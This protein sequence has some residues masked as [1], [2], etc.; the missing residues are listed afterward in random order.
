MSNCHCHTDIARDGSGQ[1]TRYLTALDPAYAEVDGRSIQD[2][3]I[4]AQKYAAQLRFYDIPG[5]ELKENTPGTKISWVEFFRRDV[6]VLAAAVTTAT[7]DAYRSQYDSL[8]TALDQTPD[9]NGF[10]ALFKP[11]IQIMV[12]L[13]GWY[14][15]AI[16]GNPIQEDLLLSIQ[17][18]LAGQVQKMK[19]YAEGYRIVDV[20]RNITLDFTDIVNDDIW[21]VNDDVDPDNTIFQ[22]DTPEDQI[23]NA[24][25]YID[26][27]FI[28]FYNSLVQL[29]NNGDGYLQFALKAYP[30]HQPHMGLF[31]SF[32]QLFQ[33]VQTQMNDITGRMLD[34]YY[35]DV[36]HLTEKPSVP[37]KA[38][39]IF[40]LAKD[41]KEYSLD[42]G[43]ALSAGK[44]AAGKEQTYI[45]ENPLV[46]NQAKVKELK[47]IFINKTP[48]DG[49]EGAKTIQTIYARPVANSQDGMGAKFIDKYP[50]WPTFGQGPASDQTFTDRICRLLEHPVP[51]TIRTDKASIGFAV[52]SPQL[53]LQGGRRW[54]MVAFDGLAQLMQQASK[55]TDGTAP[56]SI[57]FTGEKE[58][59]Q[60]NIQADLSAVYKQLNATGIFG[61]NTPQTP[62]YSMITVS[63]TAYLLIYL[64]ISA[65]SVIGFDPK[66][67]TGYAFNTSLPVMRIM[68]NPQLGLSA[69]DYRNLQASSFSIQVT[70]G[71]M[72]KSKPTSTGLTSAATVATGPFLD[73]LRT[74]VIQND[75]GI[76]PTNKPFDPFTFLPAR[77]KAFYIGSDEVFNKSLNRLG[78]NIMRTAEIDGVNNNV[79]YAVD[80]LQDRQ[81]TRLGDMYSGNN[82]SSFTSSNLCMD[83]LY[84]FNGTATPAHLTYLRDPVLPVTNWTPQT[85]KGFLRLSN[86]YNTTTGGEFP[87]P[88]P[89]LQEQAQTLEINQLSVSYVSE[90]NG[91][92]DGVDQ[93]FHVYPFG[94]AEISLTE[95]AKST[96]GMVSLR[97]NLVAGLNYLYDNRKHSA[98]IDANGTL[99]PQ[100]TFVDPYSRMLTVNNTSTVTNNDGGYTINPKAIGSRN[101]RTM[102][103]LLLHASGLDTGS[104]LNQYSGQYQEE[105]MLF[106][107]LENLQP[108][109]SL[110]L[111]FEFADGT[112]EDDEDDPP[113]IH[114]SYLINNEWRPLP[115]EALISDGTFGFQ[116]TG[117]IQIDIPEDITTKSTMITTGLSWLCASVTADA[118][119]FP[120]L[121]DVI[122]QAAE[123][124]FVDN[125]N[126]QRHFDE[127]LSAGTISKLSVKVAEVSKVQQPFASFD[128]KHK[129]VGKEFYTRVSERLRHKARAI[130]SWDYEHLVLDRYPTIYK[131]KCIPHTAPDCICWTAPSQTDANGQPLCC[132]QQIAPGHVL[133][134]PL[135][136]MKNRTAINPLQPKTS[137]RTLLEIEAYLQQRTSPFVNVRARNPVYEQILVAFKVQFITGTDKGY[138]LKKLNDEIVRFLTPWAFDDNAAPVFGQKVYA[139]AIINFIEERPYVDFITD[140]AMFVCRKD[141]CAD[142]TPAV[143]QG[144]TDLLT[145]LIN[146]TNCDEVEAATLRQPDYPGVVV[147]IPSTPRS[148]LV[149]VP[150]HIIV[151]YQAPPQVDPCTQRKMNAVQAQ[152]AVMTNVANMDTPRTATVAN[153]TSSAPTNMASSQG[154]VS[155]ANTTTYL[156]SAANTAT[157]VA[158]ITN[159][160]TPVS[161]ADTSHPVV[162]ANAV[163]PVSET[164]AGSL[165]EG[166]KTV[167]T[168]SVGEISRAANKTNT[169]DNNTGTADASADT[170]KP[171]TGKTSTK[172]RSKPKSK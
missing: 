78:V 157:P 27:I 136:N 7:P 94:V 37:D 121:I 93:F 84:A 163:N 171:A 19:A 67:H 55:I 148:I 46:I 6:A 169:P 138:Y 164:A 101:D 34:F 47:T 104:R 99:L 63:G 30:G 36:L 109:Q 5:N 161:A 167:K 77:G 111:L 56:L 68:L 23:K 124:S 61:Q 31:L 88:P 142:T 62:V 32:L 126:D 60:V 10:E 72:Y 76:Q 155:M 52:A 105:G 166:P 116:T 154:N 115:G 4:F 29:S 100:F 35:R 38:H 14:S 57:Y 106:I 156:S 43:T 120:H 96:T 44:D 149:S 1:L 165:S 97:S 130:T 9:T 83:I 42:Q 73:G 134:V 95:N 162:P 24:A 145:D 21:K 103:E 51:E 11:I 79:A 102:A 140:F 147:A 64:P 26:D 40:E 135:A 71:S 172:G 141:C 58:W 85:V 143:P 3:L 170:V 49:M 113:P 158:G 91:L 65:P 139:S 54:L 119:R 114:W 128:G 118:N 82:Y 87:P 25:L 110:S 127:A 89:S 41:V 15:V 86:L 59:L 69:Q 117:I 132:G 39:I 153:V 13:D 146:A 20:K 22:G 123:V 90:L 160:T 28:A 48:A 53:L 131:V 151:P 50:H 8:R 144:T 133:V 33:L 152:Q 81:W 17:S 45:T 70:V 2:L 16:P 12:L 98:A 159:T 125:N 129:E 66:L 108:L 74:L 112:A 122:A 107:G 80:L 75:L 150:K 18:V 137:R 168:A 92:V